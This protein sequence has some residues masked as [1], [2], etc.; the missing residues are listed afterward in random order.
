MFCQECGM[1]VASTY[2]ICPKCGGRKFESDTANHAEL[3]VTRDAVHGLRTRQTP[4]PA[5]DSV[6][7]KPESLW[8]ILGYLFSLITVI[9]VLLVAF[10]GIDITG[11]EMNKYFPVVVLAGVS[12]V[13]SYLGDN[14]DEES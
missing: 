10:T 3:S 6:D 14:K 4:P 2:K 7:K 5:F 13:F 11:G 1:E 8:T 9:Y 12:R